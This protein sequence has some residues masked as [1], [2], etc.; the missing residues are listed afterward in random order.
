VSTQYPATMLSLL[1]SQTEPGYGYL[2]ALLAMAGAVQVRPH[3]QISDT[4][5]ALVSEGKTKKGRVA[6]DPEKKWKFILWYDT[7]NTALLDH[8]DRKYNPYQHARDW[9]EKS[10]MKM[11]PEQIPE[12][13]ELHL[14][15]LYR[16]ARSARPGMGSAFEN[17]N[18]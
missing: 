17:T 4:A 7:S 11:L 15:K 3:E 12:R 18:V 5:P 6:P 2:T 16:S 8:E 9:M 14:W 10:S 13:D 1:S